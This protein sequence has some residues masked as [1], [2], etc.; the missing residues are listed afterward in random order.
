MRIAFIVGEFPVVSETFIT[1]QITGLIARGHQ[2]DIY[3]HPPQHTYQLHPDVEKYHLLAHTHY[4]PKMP[5]NYLWRFFKAIELIRKNLQK[6][7]MVVLRSLNIFKYARTAASLRLLYSAMRLLDSQPYDIIHCQFGMLGLEGMFLRDIGAIKGKLIT[8]FRGYDISWFVRKHGEHIYDSLFAQGDFFL[9]NCEYFQKKAIKLG[10]NP[11]KLVVHGSGI[12]SSLFPFKVRQPHIDGKIRIATTGRLV[13]KKGIEYA[14]RAV[15]QV[16]KSYPN[17]EYNIIGDGLL[18]PDLQQII[19]SLNITDQ[20]QLVG[21]KTQPEIVEILD[22]SD[23]FIA[24][25]ITAKDGNQDAPVNTLK[26][27]MIMGLPVIS[28]LHGGIP[29]LVNNGVSGFLVPERDSNAIASKLIYL[30]EHPEIWST[31]GQAGHAYVE[32]HYDLNRLN[33]RLVE[34]YQQVM[35]NNLSSQ[36][37]VLNPLVN[38]NYEKIST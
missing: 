36:V 17:I 19:D 24:P 20:V 9:A 29:E 16:I 23:I 34:I 12:D 18:K 14:I 6:A 4:P 10:C 35:K 5:H 33:D 25:C 32:S 1:N 31:M 13:E 27:A 2:V 30:I 37:T 22:N 28:T 7:P 38:M 8:T 15:A 3:G 11:Q 26:E 21:W